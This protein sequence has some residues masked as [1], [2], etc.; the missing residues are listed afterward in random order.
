[1][2]VY[3]TGSTGNTSLYS[4]VLGFHMFGFWGFV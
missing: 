3:V 4:G 1:M 2:D